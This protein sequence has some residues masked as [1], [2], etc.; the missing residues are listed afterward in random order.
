MNNNTRCIRCG[1]MRIEGRSWTE[2]V[3][4]SLISYT[5][6]VC[7]DPECQKIVDKQLKSRREE[8]EALHQE[9]LRRREIIRAK[10]F[11]KLK[12]A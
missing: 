5:L 12:T 11:K 4:K 10:K 7:P 6:T 9:S 2:Y 3:D 8:I 1:K